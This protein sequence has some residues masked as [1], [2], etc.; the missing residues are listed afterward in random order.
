MPQDRHTFAGTRGI[1]TT[2][3]PKLRS[4]RGSDPEF[5]QS[6]RF[7]S[8]GEGVLQQ[9]G[10]TTL[11][12]TRGW[13][14]FSFHLRP[15]TSI[16]PF[17][18]RENR[19]LIG[20]DIQQVLVFSLAVDEVVLR[21]QQTLQSFGFLFARTHGWSS[22]LINRRHKPLMVITTVQ[23]GRESSEVIV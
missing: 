4:G 13:N 10:R 19:F 11:T 17:F 5:C 12:G 23:F 14:P 7:E 3:L 2:F 16:K 9:F 22:H 8:V 6:Y 1:E 21:K 15:F 20:K 18:R